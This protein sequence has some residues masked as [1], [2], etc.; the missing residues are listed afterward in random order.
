MCLSYSAR[1][2]VKNNAPVA[3]VTK[4]HRERQVDTET[5][6]AHSR[7]FTALVNLCTLLYAWRRQFSQFHF[8]KRMP[9]AVSLSLSPSTRAHESARE[10]SKRCV[11]QLNASNSP[12]DPVAFFLLLLVFLARWTSLRLSVSYICYLMRLFM[13]SYAFTQWTRVRRDK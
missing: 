8:N 1:T 7:L 10:S 4:G 9:F 6:E 13:L 2:P 3:T 5:R 12:S 11:S